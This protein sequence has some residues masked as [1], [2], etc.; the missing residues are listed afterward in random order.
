MLSLTVR[1]GLPTC[2]RPAPRIKSFSTIGCRTMAA[3]RSRRRAKC[4]DGTNVR[5]S[6]AREKTSR[7]PESQVLVRLSHPKLA[8][9]STAGRRRVGTATGTAQEHQEGPVDP[10]MTNRVK[11][12][13]TRPAAAGFDSGR[14]RGLP[15]AQAG[16]RRSRW[17]PQHF[18]AATAPTPWHWLFGRPCQVFYDAS[19]SLPL[20]ASSY[21]HLD[22]AIVHEGA[23]VEGRQ[24]L[25]W[26]LCP[27]SLVH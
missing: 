22:V 15:Q 2:L 9:A 10:S 18:G 27:R 26:C 1:C 12:S 7:A 21:V 25:P 6:E 3:R 20:C 8:G 17:W 5:V 14:R 13:A 23:K 24:A 16:S 19:A 11:G 4:S